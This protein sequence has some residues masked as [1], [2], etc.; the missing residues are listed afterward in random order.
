MNSRGA[1]SNLCLGGLLLACSSSTSGAG[2]GGG[3]GAGS[4]GTGAGAGSSDTAGDY[5]IAPTSLVFQGRA[6]GLRPTAQSVQV[7]A[8]GVALYVKT[9]IS[10][11]AVESA[12]V[13]VTGDQS[14]VVS[15]QPAS[16]V[17]VP[18]GTSTASVSI[19]GCTDAVCSGHVAGSP[20]TVSVTYNKANG[21]L[22]GMPSSLTFTQQPGGPAPAAQS[23]S[24]RDLGDG[25]FPWTSNI[26]YQRGSGWLAVTPAAGNMLPDTASVSIVPGSVT[27]TN[28]AT[29]QFTV[30][31]TSVF[32]VAVTYAVSSDFRATPAT[33][34]VVGAFG[35]AT[36]DQ[37]LA[38]TDGLGESYSWTIKIEYQ[39]LDV[40]DWVTL[41]AASGDSLPADV[42]ISLGMMPDRLTHAATLRVTGAGT[43]HLVPISYRTP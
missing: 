10:G 13:E 25:S 26:M 30:G 12:M 15:V 3:A 6:G 37:H 38:L 40:T 5:S 28:M 36:P 17:D 35:V 39:P 1:F 24:L 41:S 22:T 31:T 14:A 18:L 11:A 8:H 21:G 20:K 19:I 33:M 9:E 4:A 23:V 27:G 7:T 2:M 43:E 32:P 42:A 16:P 29:I 34:N